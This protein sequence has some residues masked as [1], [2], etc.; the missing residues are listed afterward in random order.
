[1][2][3][4][5]TSL[6]FDSQAEEAANFYTSLFPDSKILDV[7]RYGEGTM[8]DPGSVMT[9]DF[10]LFGQSFNAI[11]GG[12]LFTFSEAISLS[13]SCA[14]QNEVDH[15]WDTLTADGGVESQCGWLKD[16]FGLSWQIVPVQL[17]ELMSNPD[18]DTS[19]RVM[20]AMLGMRK[21]SVPDLQVA[22]DG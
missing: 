6:W 21:I 8:G 7:S 12:P 20:K 22:H 3:K 18:P 11:N 1:M 5:T 10:E 13:V 19:Q 15:Y 4:I 17:M 14:D 9:V 16:R 2:Q